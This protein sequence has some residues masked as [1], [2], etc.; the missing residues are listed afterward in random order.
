MN[1]FQQGFILLCVNDETNRIHFWKWR[2]F[3]NIT[4]KMI[5]NQT[6]L[7]KTSQTVF[8][9]WPIFYVTH[10]ALIDAYVINQLTHTHTP[11][12][13]NNNNDDNDITVAQK[14]NISS[15]KN[16]EL[17]F[18]KNVIWWYFEEIDS[19]EFW[20]V[21]LIPL[22]LEDLELLPNWLYSN[23]W[24]IFGN[25]INR[26]NV[27]QIKTLWKCNNSWMHLDWHV[28]IVQCPNVACILKCTQFVVECIWSIMWGLV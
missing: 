7:S 27:I 17:I 24:A 28:I 6:T 23:V 18:K 2:F 14:K 10:A 21:D 16:Y 9:V 1:I 26:K 3:I 15:S 13:N 4:R 12:T 8:V 11:S 25:F 22:T 20:I 5:S 19:C